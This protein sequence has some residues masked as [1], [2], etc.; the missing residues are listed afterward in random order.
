M[1]RSP[2]IRL[3]DYV[4]NP[5]GGVRFA[6]ETARAL[7]ARFS[8]RLEVA[9]TGEAL[10]RYRQLL[11]GVPVDRFLDIEPAQAWRHRTILRGVPGATLLNLAL[12]TRRFHYAIPEQALEGCDLAWI[13]WLHRHRI[14]WNH[15]RA[16]VASL[17][18]LITI[19]FEG[20][21]PE[22]QRRDERRTVADWLRSDAR[23]VVS[24][25]TT[26]RQLASMY[27]TDPSRLSVVALSGQ[28]VRP[29][30]IATKRWPFS[31]RR[32]LLAPINVT[33]H[34][35]HEVLLEAVARWG[36]DVPLVLTGSGTRL[37]D[38][39]SPRSRK[40]RR[41]AETLGLVRDR[42]LFG[43]GY[44]DDA[45]YYSL[46]DGAW[47]L[48]MPTL[49]EGGGSFPVWE[50]LLQGIPV[51]SSNIAVMREM[52]DRVRGE[53]LWFDPR[54]TSEL[55]ERLRELHGDYPA[56]KQRAVSQVAR[57]EVRTWNDVAT[58]YGRIMGLLEP[59]VAMPR[60]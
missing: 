29:P 43:L 22:H 56:W 25:H 5:G 30:A 33:L 50:A 27:G 60:T 20:I 59:D 14:P 44:V 12:G 28:H 9:S 4:A 52:M 1:V 3:L 10:R 45:E 46:L 2:V 17:H 34:K 49:A 51:V 32:Y 48:V 23:I 24:S 47:A 8:C 15:S 42:S 11:E 40:L 7:V 58:E 13:P 55:V 37:W 38:D 35:N 18:D 41:L 36:A 19:Q 53:V 54:S 6:V 57:L 21:V 31:G 39:E 16:V 26:A